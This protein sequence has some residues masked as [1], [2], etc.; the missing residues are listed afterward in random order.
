MDGCYAEPQSNTNVL[1][2]KFPFERK[3]EFTQSVDLQKTN[4]KNRLGNIHDNY[5]Y[6]NQLN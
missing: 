2:Q 4:L 6:K 1:V 3:R 5:E